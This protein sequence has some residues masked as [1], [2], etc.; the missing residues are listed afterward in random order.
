MDALTI[1]QHFFPLQGKDIDLLYP[2]FEEVVVPKNTNVIEVDRH[3]HYL[4]FIKEGSCRIFYYKEEKEVILDFAFPGD[5]LMS[6]NSYVHG[7]AGYENIQTMEDA[8]LYRVKANALQQ[9]FHESL[10]IANWGRKLA[11]VE[12]LKIEY[13]LMSKLFKT[14]AESYKE[15][16]ERAPALIHHIKLGFIASYLG[17]SQVTLSRIRAKI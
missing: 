11:E 15:L 8:V 10:G 4:Y 1:I 2:L 3:S 7:K 12:T 14:A 16:L 13:R 5:A 6:L 9:L 17:I